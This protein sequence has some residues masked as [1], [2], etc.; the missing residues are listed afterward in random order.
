METGK[1]LGQNS[2]GALYLGVSGYGTPAAA[3]KDRLRYRFY[4]SGRERVYTLRNVDGA[5]RL[6]NRLREGARYRLALEGG[7]VCGVEETT[8]TAA[9]RIQWVGG[10]SI[11]LDGHQPLPLAP[12]AP[13]THL[14]LRPGGAQ[15]EAAKAR[16]GDWVRVYG[17]PVTQIDRCPAVQ[18]YTP[19]VAYT[20]GLRTLK[21]LLAAALQPVGTTLYLYGGGWNWQ[22]DGPARQAV[23][24]GLPQSWVAFFQS[25]GPD[26]AYRADSCPAHSWYP[27]G[28]Y[29][30][31]YYAGADCSGYLGWTIYQVMHTLSSGGGYVCPAAG[32]ARCL[33]ERWGFGT[34]SRQAE[35]GAFRPGDICSVKGHVWLCLGACR[36]GSLVILHATPSPSRTGKPGGGVQLSGLGSTPGCRAAELAKYY[37]S[38]CFPAW[39]GR[40]RAVWKPLDRYTA[41]DGETAGRFSWHLGGAGLLDPE[42]YGRLGAE[43]ILSDLCGA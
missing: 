17:C 10:A 40:Y 6:Q 21:N 8:P 14:A 43:D 22:D 20:P 25:Q 32:M 41:L 28:G 18:P 33:A 3:D 1:L 4:H 29:N 24:I 42:G 31:Y 12:G 36:D 7:I 38:A 23:S 13:V 16:R 15:V 26:F 30:Q 2:A 11:T 5:Y 35:A 19:P 34:W 9:G 27:F 39:S 37:M